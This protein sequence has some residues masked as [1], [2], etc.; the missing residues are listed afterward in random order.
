MTF[1]II[2]MYES[3]QVIEKHAALVEKNPI[4]RRF[5]IGPLWKWSWVTWI[6]IPELNV[7][8]CMFLGNL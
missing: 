4:A 5:N 6:E 2:C 8:A 1:Q 7:D 3:L